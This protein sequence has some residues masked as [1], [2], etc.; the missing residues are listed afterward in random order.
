MKCIYIIDDYGSSRF[1]GIGSYIRELIYCFKELCHQVNMIICNYNVE[2][3]S[4]QCEDGVKKLLVPKTPAFCLDHYCE[5]ISLLRLHITDNPNNVFIVN[6]GPSSSFLKY[7]KEKF[8]Q[9]KVLFVIHDMTWTYDLM[10]NDQKYE[11][12]YTLKDTPEINSKYNSMFKYVKA[13]HEMYRIVDKIILLSEDTASLFEKYYC[14][15]KQCLIHNGLRDNFLRMT[16]EQ[17]EIIK[18]KHHLN[19]SEKIIVYTGRVLRAKGIYQLLTCFETVLKQYPNC[20]LV[21]IGTVFDPSTL[22]SYARKVA[23][24]VTFTGQVSMEEVNEWYQIANI[25]VL[26]SYYEQCSYT[27]IE[28]LMYGLPIVATD[29]FCIRNMF[30]DG[31][32]ARIAKIE[33]YTNPALF[34]KN[35]AK[36]ILDLLTSPEL[37]NRL[38][39]GARAKYESCYRI[40]YMREKYEG[41]LQSL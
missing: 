36:A 10:G 16:F 28:M 26:P 35:L 7:L 25:G 39:L 21:I 2:L 23:A 40:E 30:T 5:L 33:D 1:N 15:D 34:E 27:G 41:L 31:V 22:F 19:S 6:H 38:R 37:C 4:I 3:F 29:G 20:R 13:E 18:T 32:N 11:E 12:L 8:P 17:I 24:K 14:F 9:S